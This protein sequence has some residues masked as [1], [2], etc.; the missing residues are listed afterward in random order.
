MKEEIKEKIEKIVKRE[1]I[2]TMK[3]GR[4][5]M[6]LKE[7]EFILGIEL[8]T[9]VSITS[10]YEDDPQETMIGIYVG[11]I[12]YDWISLNPIF[13]VPKIKRTLAGIESWWKLIP[14]ED[15]NLECNEMIEKNPIEQEKIREFVEILIKMVNLE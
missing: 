8:G 15:L 12:K 11:G 9:L 14:E 10:V 13:Y 5:Y 3:D 1:D 4:E 2:H 6:I 7:K